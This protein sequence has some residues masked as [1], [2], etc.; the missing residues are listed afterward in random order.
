MNP[1]LS[2]Q[3]S[4][5]LRFNVRALNLYSCGGRAF[6]FV[7]QMTDVSQPSITVN[8]PMSML[9]DLRSRL[10]N[11]LIQYVVKYHH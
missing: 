4:L 10:G 9:V 1:E 5:V 7:Q 3:S 2:F 11:R 6:W 8:E